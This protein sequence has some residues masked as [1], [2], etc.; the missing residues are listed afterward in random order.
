MADDWSAVTIN[1]PEAVRSLDWLKNIHDVQGGWDAIAQLRGDG[2][3]RNSHLAEG[4]RR[5][6]LR[7]LCRARANGSRRMHR[8]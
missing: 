2:L 3:H 8:T 1:S 6:L 7:D 5:A 4:A